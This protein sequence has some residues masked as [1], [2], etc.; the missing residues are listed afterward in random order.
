MVIA[1]R[2]PEF[3]DHELESLHA[4]AVRLQGS[5]SA[6]Q[7]RQ[8]EELLPSLSVALEERR[9]ARLV[10]QAETR[11]ENTRKRAA[12]KASKL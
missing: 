10:T 7:Q 8:A 12:A 11:R 2:I 3:S 6:A 5:G 4:N 1:D 9:A